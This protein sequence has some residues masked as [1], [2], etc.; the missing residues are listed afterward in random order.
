[1]GG[2][3]QPDSPYPDADSSP[4]PE[5]DTPSEDRPVDDGSA[6]S[7]EGEDPF[8]ESAGEGVEDSESSVDSDDRD[9]SEEQE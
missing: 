2:D 1:M 4:E 7:P 8:V 3:S 5:G 9:A 6:E